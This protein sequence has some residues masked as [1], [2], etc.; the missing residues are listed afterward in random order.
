MRKHMAMLD[1]MLATAP[2]GGGYLCGGS[3]TAADILM[4]FPLLASRGGR[5]QDIGH[6]E[7]GCWTSEFPRVAAYAERLESEEGYKRSV[8]KVEELDGKFE[9]T[10]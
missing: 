5:L 10:L 2:D 6:W 1:D 7:G 9:A 8:R 4:S 3:L